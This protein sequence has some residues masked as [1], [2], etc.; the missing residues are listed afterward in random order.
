MQIKLM[1]IICVI[2]LSVG[3]VLFKHVANSF[4]KND[5]HLS[6]NISVM[7]V[8]AISI[9]AVTTLLWIWI[10]R[11]IDL[12]KVYPFMALA[13]IFVPLGS[14]FFLGEVFDYHYLVGLVMIVLGVTIINL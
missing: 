13:F 8:T 1:A 5:N 10:L 2:F 9:Y 14:Y 6:F 4:A 11:E 3:Q 7:L 12:S